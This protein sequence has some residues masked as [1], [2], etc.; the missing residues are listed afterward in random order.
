[1]AFA[2][3]QSDGR[4]DVRR[5]ARSHRSIRK[6]ERPARM[7]KNILLTGGA[8]FIGSHLCDRLLEKGCNVRVL[9]ALV[10]QVH[11]PERARPA[12]LSEDAELIVADV[13]DRRSVD[14]ALRGI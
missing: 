12:A 10:A 7:A 9:D 2:C 4:A 5:P 8:G 11:G 13:R 14:R 3:A 1:M 6:G